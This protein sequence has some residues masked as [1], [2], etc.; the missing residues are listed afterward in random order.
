VARKR[1]PI[2]GNEITHGEIVF[3]TEGRLLQELGERLVA[4]AEVALVELVKN[5]YDADARTCEVSVAKN[6]IEIRDDGHGMTFEQFAA[7]W[8]RIATSHK[9][10]ETTSPAFGRRR[11]GQ[12]G[13][14]RFA[15]RFLGAKVRLTTIAWDETRKMKT[16]LDA[17]F[18]WRSIDKAPDLRSAKIPYRLTAVSKDRRTGTV[19]RVEALKE[20]PDFL[21]AKSFR[22]M[23]L[24]IVSPFESLNRGRFKPTER[25]AKDDP[26]FRVLLP[27]MGEQEGE[28]DLAKQVLQRAWAELS[29]DLTSRAVVFKVRLIASQ[30]TETLKVGLQSKISSGCFAD[31]RFFPRRAGVFSGAPFD[32]REAWT[33][34]RENS[35]IAVVDHGFRIKPYG[36]E[37][38]DW[39]SLD[40]DT[41]HNRRDWRSE[42]ATKHFSIPEEQRRR[43][44]DNPALNLPTNFQLVGAVFVESAP[45]SLSAE[46]GDLTPAMDREGYLANE[47]YDQ[48]VEVV[49][50]GTEFLAWV[51]KKDILE[52]QEIKAKEAAKRAREDFKSAIKWIQRSKTLTRSDKAELV[53]H[54][55]SLAKRLE[56]V[57]EYDREARRKL[58]TMS[59]LGVV[60]GFM[61]HEASR[62]LDALERAMTKLKALARKDSG[63]AAALK[64]IEEGYASFKGQ[65]EYTSTFVESIHQE[66]L[67]A[68][69]VAPQVRR[70]V[71]RFGT[72]ASA[73]D[74]VVTNEVKA[75]VEAP[76]APIAL[77]SGVLL[78]LYTNALKA[79]VAAEHR[80]EPPH[81][82]FRAWNEPTRH[83]LEV[84]DKGI[85]IPPELRQRVFDPLFTTTSNLN[86]PLGSGMGL[87]LSLIKELLRH[88]HGSIRIVDPPNGFSTCFRIELPKD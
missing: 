41:A 43:P 36:F 22:T 79:V 26:G 23:V 35:G 60:A 83:V 6:A 70:I 40:N 42:I 8:M 84:A 65:V 18:D 29:I 1:G 31:I 24:K 44:G 32:G 12:K 5:A 50:A 16:Q 56:E 47:A 20:D 74:I 13:I 39:L 59:L 37:D 87:G 51:D 27:G 30:R 78:N 49:R 9:L 57:E 67:T 64:E 54:Y 38:N 77:Y 34:V 88:V 55:A 10:S 63:I 3:E 52:R 21:A 85:G 75:D 73:R 2:A 82:V 7:R 19:L 76:P 53:S 80:E 45:P 4:S 61:T 69:K 25:A 11:T 17:D 72:F 66:R 81:I 86:N 48:L 33:W 15:V 58:E 28:I 62:I 14:G 71:D 68:F 46:A